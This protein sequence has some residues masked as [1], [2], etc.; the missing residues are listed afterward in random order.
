MKDTYERKK[1]GKSGLM[2]EMMKEMADEPEEVYMGANKK[3]KS[4]KYADLVEE[5]EVENFTR[6]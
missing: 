3:S 2:Q 5:N 1:L 4:N 6:Y